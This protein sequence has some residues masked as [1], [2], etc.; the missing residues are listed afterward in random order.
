MI[1]IFLTFVFG[2]GAWVTSNVLNKRQEGELRVFDERLTEERIELGKQQER[3]AKAEKSL[4]EVKNTAGDANEKAGRANERAANLE[5]ANFR[6]KKDAAEAKAAQL[7]LELQVAEQQTEL[8][9]QR[10]KAAGAEAKLLELQNKVAD[11]DLSPFERQLVEELRGEPQ[12]NVGL[13]SLSNDPE[14]GRFARQIAIVLAEAGWNKGQV[15]GAILTA[16]GPFRGIEMHLAG[17]LPSTAKPPLN[18]ALVLPP[19]ASSMFSRASASRFARN[20]KIGRA[21]A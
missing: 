11:R 8:A 9:A 12:Q 17:V 1:A 14:A 4:A 13:S 21:A 20:W 10:E 15:S 6:L 16:G 7:Q 19:A 18:A 5:S 3:A 2:G